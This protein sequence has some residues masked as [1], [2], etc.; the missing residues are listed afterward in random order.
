MV[1]KISLK[2][3]PIPADEVQVALSQGPRQRRHRGG[4]RGGERAARC[5]LLTLF[6]SVC[7]CQRVLPL[8]HCWLLPSCAQVMLGSK[9]LPYESI[10]DG[11]RNV[12]EPGDG[13]HVPWRHV[14]SAL[15]SGNLR[16]VNQ[17]GAGGWMRLAC[18]PPAGACQ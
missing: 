6:G 12:L 17:V 16:L 5:W 9:R 11:S 8:L 10:Q 1:S 4:W 18:S 14:Y 7:S 15:E 2:S 3:S 13:G